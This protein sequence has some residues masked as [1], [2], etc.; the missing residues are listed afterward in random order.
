MENHRSTDRYAVEPA[1]F[2]AAVAGLSLG[3]ARCGT[4]R[5]E[6]EAGLAASVEGS[7]AAAADAVIR[8]EEEEAVAVEAAWANVEAAAAAVEEAARPADTL[9][10]HASEASFSSPEEATSG[11]GRVQA[12]VRNLE[13]GVSAETVGVRYGAHDSSRGRAMEVEIEQR[14]RRRARSTS[15]ID[16][17][18][19]RRPLEEAVVQERVRHRP[20]DWRAPA[21]LHH[22]QV[23]QAG[24]G[25]ME[26]PG[27]YGY[28]P[29]FCPPPAFPIGLLGSAPASGEGR[30]GA[31][32]RR[33][34]SRERAR[35]D[36]RVVRR[37]KSRSPR[38]K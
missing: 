27:G 31:R 36:D 4:A 20:D 22:S 14:R 29:Q 24:H 6:P 12:A 21:S 38:R 23:M 17:V 9:E 7:N 26:R 1:E 34:R 32:R 13:S 15:C 25:R 30:D 28:I 18:G 2:G 35:E 3:A 16:D 37:G 11:R 10:V 5:L 33:R 19:A 8:A